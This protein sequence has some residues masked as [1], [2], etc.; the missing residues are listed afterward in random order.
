MT[1]T[2]I[3]LQDLRRRMYLKAKAEP[4]HRFW[5]L[6]I[7][8]WKTET[9]QAAY[10]M[11][12][13]N[14][15]AP[16]SDGVTFQAIEESGLEDF[17]RQ[18]QDELITHTYRPLR[19]R[20]HEI[21]KGGG[22]VRLLSIPS[23]RD[24]VVQGALKLIL[25]PIFEADFQPRS[26]GYRPKR[27]AHQAINS[28]ARA[29]AYNK[30]RI[31]DLDLRAYFDNIRHHTL[32]SKI[33]RRVSDADVM[34]LL[35]LTLESSGKKGLPQGGV[36]SP[37]LSN[38][39]LNEVDQMLER[40]VEKTRRGRFTYLEYA[41]FADDMV[42]LIDGFPQHQWLIQAV[43]KRLREE[44]AKLQVELNEEKSR[45]VDLAKDESFDFLGFQFRR[46]MGRRGL[47][48]AYYIPRMKKRT[49]LLERLKK[50]F[51]HH[52]SQPA[53]QVI[54]R[55]NPI[56]R[57]WVNYFGVGDSSQCFNYVK[58]WVEKRVRR[59]LMYARKRRGFGWKR[60]SRE[61]IYEGLGLFN[62]Y[63][64]HRFELHPKALP[65]R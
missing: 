6:F 52:K 58:S 30:T 22:K 26:Y 42:I 39:Y 11:A 4:A 65:A 51:R 44:L 61:R 21:P 48:K 35:K 34:W 25:E 40:A 24:R 57:G 62:G 7:H 55:I 12:K 28:V 32:L 29:I 8:V 36:I 63:R 3:S 1:K 16:G 9:L 19:A 45:V 46:T 15:G 31:I 5:G 33:A 38:L 2:P 59:H 27:T 10:R 41:R 23:I 20:K 56:I 47:W 43:L 37:V 64:L 14:D 53:E 60:W 13:E 49:E 18:I 50:V 17:L 54:Q